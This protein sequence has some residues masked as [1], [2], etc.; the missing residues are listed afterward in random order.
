MTQFVDNNAEERH[1]AENQSSYG[2]F[3]SARGT[4]EQIE[5]NQD[6]NGRLD[7]ERKAEKPKQ[8]K[9]LSSANI[10]VLET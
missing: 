8:T 3:R 7:V 9:S 5:E 2:S 6:E 1:E 10:H 4:D